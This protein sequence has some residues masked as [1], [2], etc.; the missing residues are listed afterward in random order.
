MEEKPELVDTEFVLEKPVAPELENP[1]E[2]D[3]EE[4]GCPEGIP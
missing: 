2:E 1:L 3:E 4:I